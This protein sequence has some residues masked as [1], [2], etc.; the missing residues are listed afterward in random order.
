MK[1]IINKIMIE[2]KE[3]AA[4]S[5]S[6]T[7]KNHAKLKQ[8]PLGHVV[9]SG[10][11]REQLLRNKDGIGGHLPELEPRM[12]ATPYTT[13]ETEPRWGE[14]RKAGWGAEISGNYWNG[15]VELAFTL[16]DDELKAKAEK[17][18]NEVLSYQ[19]VDGYLGTYTETDN[20]FDDYNAWGTY[21][22]M[23]ALMAY[24]EATGRT[25]VLTAVHRCFLWFCNNWVGDR[26]TRYGGVSI[27][28]GMMRCYHHT[29]DRRL[30]QFCED[31]Y[32]FL[33]KNDLFDLSLDAMNSDQLHYNSNHG[34]G[35]ANHIG[36]PAEVYTG[37][38]DPHYLKA[39]INAFRKCKSKVVHITG[40]I[41]CESEYLVPLGSNVET[42]Y[43]GFA[44]YL[45]S[46]A[47]LS[48][49]TGDTI[50]GDEMERVAFNGAQGARKK[51]ERA[52]AYL[53][54][55]NQVFATSSSSYADGL[56]QVYAP[57][58]PV[59]CCP[60]MSVRILPEFI[61]GMVLTDVTDDP[62]GEIDGDLYFAAYAP[63]NIIHGRMHIDV[64]TLYPFRDHIDFRIS[65]ADPL[66]K[67][68]HFRIPAWC[69]NAALSINGETQA[70]E[71]IP[72]TY[73]QL[74]HIW[75]DGDVITLRLPMEVR[76]SKMNDSDRSSLY[77]MAVEYGALVFALPVPERWEAW[78]GKPVSPLPEGWHWYNVYPDNKESSLDVYDNMGMRKHLINYNVALDEN[79]QPAD[80]DVHLCEPDGYPWEKPFIKMML[81]AY[82]A[83]Y[84]YPPYPSKTFEPYC[85]DGKAYVTDRLK[86]ELIPYGC[87]SLRITYIPRAD[88]S[89]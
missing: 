68:L 60:V 74:K 43:C 36:Q 86:I 40:G 26:K 79:I 13:K 77:P 41:T 54:S 5:T 21:C 61:C 1:S 65:L 32:A 7:T 24:Y 27:T 46:L 37:N 49:I 67:T 89:D 23:N 12:I 71:C 9:A 47:E 34:A 53:T 59:S 11:L 30:L 16:N 28:E 58:V 15:L 44:M 18:V 72:A 70:V 83:P 25:D 20:L 50:Y 66:E 31:Y 48:R 14:A 22:G 87:T 2:Q 81:P 73:T 8:L 52:I 64:V 42:E 51:D 80:V 85:E 88:L 76:I 17:W 19:R 29:G 45:K 69:N 35:Y 10:W 63:V 39:S 33:S 75:A 62:T 55:P 82:K 6:K 4:S 84:S 3:G 38:G 57:C 78:D 56:H